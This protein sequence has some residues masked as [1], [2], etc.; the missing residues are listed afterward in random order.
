MVRGVFLA[1]CF[2]LLVWAGRVSERSQ[3]LWT[4]V[5][6]LSKENLACRAACVSEAGSKPMPLH[7]LFRQSFFD[8]VLVQKMCIL[9][10]WFYDGR[11]HKN[12]QKTFKSWR[13]NT[14]FQL[15]HPSGFCLSKQHESCGSSRRSSRRQYHL[16]DAVYAH[17]WS[18]GSMLEYDIF[19]LI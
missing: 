14:T 8:C 6:D 19:L 11:L 10:L 18:S 5:A 9:A 16:S 17:F 4:T 1:V 7:W 2:K 12:A 3:K 15:L 13:N